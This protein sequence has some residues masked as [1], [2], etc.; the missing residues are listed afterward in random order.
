VQRQFTKLSTIL[1]DISRE[2]PSLLGLMRDRQGIRAPIGF[3]LPTQLCIRGC[4]STLAH[5][6]PESSC[7]L[8]YLSII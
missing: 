6:V 8:C 5:S 7:S 3:W 2:W 4:K 1:V